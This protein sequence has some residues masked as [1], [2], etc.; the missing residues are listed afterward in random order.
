M[1]VTK[2]LAMNAMVQ[3]AT[4][5]ATIEKAIQTATKNPVVRKDIQAKVDK[6]VELH[7]LQKKLEAR[8]KELRQDIEPYMLDKNIMRIE[9][10]KGAGAIV[11]E[12]SQR[13]EVTAK[14]TTYNVMDVEPFLDP[15]LEKFCITRVVDRDSL[16]YLVKSG[17]VS[18]EVYDYKITKEVN[19]LIVK[20]Y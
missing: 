10:T 16:E 2:N 17:Q 5:V 1:E 20:K 8:L 12:R 9:D 13:P 18:R 4:E 7:S 19:K 14:Y 3:D 11:T 6:Y 15:E